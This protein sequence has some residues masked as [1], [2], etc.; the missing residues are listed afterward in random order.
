[1]LQKKTVR[2]TI[3]ANQLIRNIKISATVKAPAGVRWVR[4]RS[5]AVNQHMD[6][7]TKTMLARKGSDI[8][9]ATIPARQIDKQF[10]LMYFIEVMDS[11]G[12]GRIYPD[13]ELETPYVVIKLERE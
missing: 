5:R 1:M 3:N 4:L 13:F 12:R 11:E 2:S 6:Y 7:K 8:F 9:T 10:D